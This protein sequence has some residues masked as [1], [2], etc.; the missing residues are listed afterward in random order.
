MFSDK[1]SV[2]KTDTL[3]FTP[4]IHCKESFCIWGFLLK[5][6]LLQNATQ[7]SLLWHQAICTMVMTRRVSSLSRSQL[8]PHFCLSWN[9]S[10]A[11]NT[12]SHAEC[13][14]ELGTARIDWFGGRK[15]DWYQACS[16]QNKPVEA[17]RICRP[18]RA[19][20]SHTVQIKYLV[21][22]TVLVS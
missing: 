5:C 20:S 1:F 17:T 12:D 4:F 2:V 11:P 22:R 21:Y 9:L 10:Q 14:N 18:C 6:Y 15:P 16:L 8:A 13:S 19:L 3:L 7:S